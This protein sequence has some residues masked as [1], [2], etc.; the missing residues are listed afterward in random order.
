MFRVVQLTFATIVA[1]ESGLALAMSHQTFA[2][3]GAAVGAVMR[4][5]FSHDRDEGDLLGVA[6]VIVNREEPVPLLHVVSHFFLD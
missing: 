2:L 3:A 5:V 6:V 1:T 4:H